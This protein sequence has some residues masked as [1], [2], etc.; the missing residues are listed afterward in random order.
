M[1]DFD[2]ANDTIRFLF[3]QTDIV[4]V[5]SLIKEIKRFKKKKNNKPYIS[6]LIRNTSGFETKSL[7]I[8]RPKLSIHDNYNDD[9]KEIH[10]VILKRL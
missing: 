6:L 7:E 2:S 1:V 8:R 4:K 5:E 9:F 10:Q 3:S